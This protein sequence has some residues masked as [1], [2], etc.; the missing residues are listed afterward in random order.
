MRIQQN[1]T[2]GC[3]LLSVSPTPTIYPAMSAT[4]EMDDAEMVVRSN[5]VDVLSKLQCDELERRHKMCVATD[6]ES[7]TLGTTGF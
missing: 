5:G 1:A 2:I 3:L 6:F 4:N 7:L